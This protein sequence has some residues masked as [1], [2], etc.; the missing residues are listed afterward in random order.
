MSYVG[1]KIASYDN[2]A[3][4]KPKPKYGWQDIYAQYYKGVGYRLMGNVDHPDLDIFPSKYNINNIQ[5]HA[6]VESK[7]LHLSIWVASWL[8]R[9]GIPLNLTKYSSMLL[10]ISHILFNW[11]GTQTGVMHFVVQG[12]DRKGNK[13]KKKWFLIAE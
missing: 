11:M 13:C 12:N 9:A 4:P 8:V 10:N 5:F 7:I 6:G 2:L 3:K 1:K